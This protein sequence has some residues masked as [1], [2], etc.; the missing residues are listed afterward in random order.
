M[1]PE[2]ARGESHK[3]D[4]RSDVYSLGVI[5][6]ELLA[7]E[8]PF[9]GNVRMLL[10]QVL[11]DEPRS[12]RG[13]NDRVPRALETVCLK[14]L[15]KEPA[16]RYQT[17]GEFADDLR[18]FLNNEP[19]HA[20]P[21]GVLERASKWVRRHPALAALLGVSTVA[22]AAVVTVVLL[23]N[24]GLARQRDFAL[25][26]Q[27]IARRESEAAGRERA[28][29]E[30][31]RDAA[32]RAR[33]AA[34]R[35]LELSRRSLYALQLAE[36]ASSWERDPSR[37]LALLLDEERC[38]G[39]FRDFS[40]G[41]FHRLCKRDRLAIGPTRGGCWPSRSRRTAACS[42]PPARTAASS[43]G[44]P[45]RAASGPP[46]PATPSGPAPSSF[47]RTARRSSPAAV[48]TPPGCGT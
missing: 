22:A 29:A 41:L 40:W 11:H 17:A 21:A 36:V 33:A 39:R 38:P 20:R 45:R 26:Q 43:S 15:E 46:S 28:E 44:T 7:G 9:R 30:K 35:Q 16:R 34:D 37:G 6:Y 25:E 32:T 10:H 2:Q 12:P 14:A 5:L 18:R 19:I 42:P 23:S 48:T 1:S 31:Q 13:F 27:A 8:L 24:A 3:V 47:R 4:G